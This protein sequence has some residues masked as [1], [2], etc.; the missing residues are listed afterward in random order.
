M[1]QARRRAVVRHRALDASRSQRG[2]LGVTQANLDEMIKSSGPG[3]APVSRARRQVRGGPRPYANDWVVH[4]IGAVGKYGESLDR[5]LGANGRVNLARGVNSLWT[6]DGFQYAPPLRRSRF[7]RAGRKI[8]A[9][10]S[11]VNAA[12]LAECFFEEASSEKGAGGEMMNQR[13]AA[14]R[15]NLFRRKAEQ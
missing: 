10:L 11:R 13:L 8:V 15:Y 9:A 2:E 1:G 4:I 5:H 14:I 6:R 7:V 12:M 3:A